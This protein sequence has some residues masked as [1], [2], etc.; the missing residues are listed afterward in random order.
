MSRMKNPIGNR[1]I[2]SLRFTRWDKKTDCDC[3][4]AAT[5]CRTAACDSTGVICLRSGRFV[6]IILDAMY[7]NFDHCS[8]VRERT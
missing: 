8:G 3:L 7:S 2:H 1:C 4:Y 6:R 5:D